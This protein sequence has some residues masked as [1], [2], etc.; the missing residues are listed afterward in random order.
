MSIS[1]RPSVGKI[2]AVVPQTRCDLLILVETCTVSCAWRSAAA[3]TSVSGAACT[4]FPPS[5][6]KILACPSRSARIAFT[7]SYPSLSGRLEAELG[8]Q[9]VEEVSRRALPDAH[10][11]VALH[12]GVATYRQQPSTWLTDIALRQGEIDDFGDRGHRIVMLGQ[13]HGPAEH[14]P[15]GLAEQLRRLGDLLRGTAR[16]SPPR[17]PNRWP[18][19]GPASSRSHGYAAQ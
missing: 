2:N 15:I 7:V 6:M 1:V 4:K 11:A 3:V 14:R 17:D 16:W 18:T 10:R 13:A 19:R 12:V 9:P 5:P 8:L